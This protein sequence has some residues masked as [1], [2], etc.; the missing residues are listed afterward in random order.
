MKNRKACVLPA[1][2]ELEAELER[3]K[4]KKRYRRVLQ[5]TVYTLLVVAAVSVLISTLVMPVFQ[6]YGSSMSPTLDE[7]EIVVS[8]KGTDFQRGD[9]LAFYYNNKILV[10]RLIGKPGDWIDMDS[11][12]AVYVNGEALDE[13]YLTEQAFGD[14]NIDL[15]CQVPDNRYFVMGDRRSSSMDSRNT[16]VGCIAEEQIVGRIV[17]RVWPFSVFGPV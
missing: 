4:Y 12:G 11:S 16:E 3:E 2:S 5:S 15:P 8:L 7:G 10:K 6:I 13:P 9:V 14:C 17:F 1:L